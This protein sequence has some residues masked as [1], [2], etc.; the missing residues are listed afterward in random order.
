[1]SEK[2]QLKVVFSEVIKDMLDHYEEYNSNEQEKIKDMLQDLVI[3]NESLKTYDTKV[4]SEFRKSLNKF[5]GA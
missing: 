5:F 3:M 4:I 2:K 1:M